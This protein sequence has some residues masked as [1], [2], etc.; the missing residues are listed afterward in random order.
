MTVTVTVTVVSNP[1]RA[2]SLDSAFKAEFLHSEADKTL[3]TRR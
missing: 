2:A 3:E 1:E